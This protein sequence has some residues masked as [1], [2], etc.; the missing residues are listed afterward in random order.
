MSLSD[1]GTLQRFRLRTWSWTLIWNERHL[2]HALHE[3]EQFYNG[4][5]SHQGIANARPL[6]PLRLRLAAL[7]SQVFGDRR[8]S[9]PRRRADLSTSH[10]RA[11]TAKVLSRCSSSAAPEMGEQRKPTCPS[12]RTR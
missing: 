6:H 9:S 8:R 4:H 10:R 1:V 7:I 11:Y 5:R 2:L 12:G 3:F